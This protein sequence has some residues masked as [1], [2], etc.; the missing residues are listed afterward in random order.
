MRFKKLD[1]NLLVALD[2]LLTEQHVAKTAERL[3]LSPS[4]TSNALARL[5]TYFNDD[6]LRSVG[7]NMKVT[8][9]GEHLQLS[10]RQ[11]LSQ[12]ETDILAPRCFDPK[13]S[14]SRFRICSSDFVQT[15]LFPKLVN[16]AAIQSA[17]VIFDFVS[18]GIDDFK[19]M[20]SKGNDVVILPKPYTSSELKKVD[21]FEDHFVCMMSKHSPYAKEPLT[22][23][24][25]LSASHIALEHVPGYPEVFEEFICAPIDLKRHIAIRCSSM[26]AI[27][28]LLQHS[29]HIVTVPSR[30]ALLHVNSG[31][32]II[33]DFPFHSS[34][35]TWC[36]HWQSQRSEEAGMKWLLEL[37]K[38]AANLITRTELMLHKTEHRYSSKA[39]NLC[40]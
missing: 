30:F 22:A 37:I 36:A 3:N 12:I 34:P 39:I 16:L 9:L 13:E 38:D 18:L 14:D 29:Q 25:Y 20:D 23:D 26:S 24:T 17:G 8:E 4:A 1:L 6:L 33:Q 27:P 35:I 28:D 15:L 19:Q 32:L 2:A 5:R 7:R 11:V 10:V 21:L 40:I 31:D